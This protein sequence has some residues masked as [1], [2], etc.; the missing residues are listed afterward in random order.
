MNNMIKK[1]FTLCLIFFLGSCVL[2]IG[3]TPDAISENK[4][5]E[6]RFPENKKAVIILGDKDDVFNA[7]SLWY[8]IDETNGSSIRNK[9]IWIKRSID[10]EVIMLEPGIYSLKSFEISN[11]SHARN[12]VESK[13]EKIYDIKTKKPAFAS[14]VVRSG[15]VVYLG[16]LRF[17]SY[18]V[19][20][21]WQNNRNTIVRI[22]VFDEDNNA[23]QKFYSKYPKLKD[24]KV[25]TRLIEVNEKN[26]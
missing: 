24:Y 3:F 6:Q 20:R 18:A 1:I 5:I 14:F 15:E 26:K 9:F 7:S 17:S 10:K 12:W 8:K 16:D 2:N 19:G 25:I 21:T 11:T 22:K 4:L 13:E 23:K